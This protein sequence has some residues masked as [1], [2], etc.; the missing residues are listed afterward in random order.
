LARAAGT[1]TPS[2]NVS[3]RVHKSQ[4]ALYDCRVEEIAIRVMTP[5]DYEAVTR[6]WTAA[7]LSFRPRG[8]DRLEKM[9]VEM[10]RG[11]ALFFI[12]EAGEEIVGVV[13]G[14]HDG[15]RGWINRLAVAPAYQ[16]RGIARMLVREVEARA[17]ALG[18]EIVAALIESD[19]E[20]SL[21]FF[22]AI[23]YLHA[24]HIEYV[25]KRRSADT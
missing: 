19:N 23:D 16:R 20:A 24:P 15:R 7:G 25:S 13:L 11:T 4:S 6:L 12:A 3:R 14:T 8:R 2:L 17:E 21:A 1:K 22:R 9:R 5:D 18:I 10:E